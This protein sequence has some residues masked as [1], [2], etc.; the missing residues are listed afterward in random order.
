[1]TKEICYLDNW[2]VISMNPYSPP[3]NSPMCLLGRVYNHKN[4][5]DGKRIQTSIVLDIKTEKGITLVE[6]ANTIY[7]VGEPSPKY[8]A[9]CK[10]QGCHVPTPETPFII[11]D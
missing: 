6:T 9:W 5:T 11:K 1:M 2:S 3:E 7:K 10:S 8:V 4:F